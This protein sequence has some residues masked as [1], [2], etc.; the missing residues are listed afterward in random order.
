[1]LG[2]L[3]LLLGLVTAPVAR[4]EP[5]VEGRTI[6]SFTV[7]YPFLDGQWEGILRAS[8][9]RIYFF[10]STHSPTRAAHFF[11]Y[12]PE[13]SAVELLG[14]IGEVLGEN[15]KGTAPQSKVHSALCEDRGVLYFTTAWGFKSKD[16][17]YPGGHFMSFDI[18]TRKFKDYGIPLPGYG[19]IA[20]IHDPK[21][22][23]CYSLSCSY[24]EADEESHL[25]IL[26]PRDGTMTDKGIVLTRQNV[27]R[28]MFADRRG[29]V[30]W[31]GAAGEVSY[32]DPAD[33]AVHKAKPIPPPPAEGLGKSPEQ[34]AKEHAW[35]W[36]VWDDRTGLAYGLVTV[37]VHLFSLDPVRG[38]YEDLG[39]F[40]ATGA[41]GRPTNLGFALVPGERLYYAP[42]G[43]G[44]Y[45]HLTSYDIRTGRFED[46]GVICVEEG[47]RVVEAHSM[48]VGKDGRLYIVASVYAIEGRDPVVEGRQLMGGR[49]Y[50]MK[51][52]VVKPGEDRGK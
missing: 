26:A 21:T 32:Y 36:I 12:D 3:L 2:R 38:L 41:E 35:R 29:C 7:E 31:S 45:T 19:L 51:F 1:M 28:V 52:I 34:I 42:W 15:G 18:R 40:G 46:H 10:V 39:Y 33:D 37:N 49:P 20:M 8:D 11:C 25:I 6:K 30:Y 23:R 24:P 9:G 44:R 4:A 22:R 17:K 16:A 48:A 43:K 13:K 14:D 50:E 5:V 47:R 27:C